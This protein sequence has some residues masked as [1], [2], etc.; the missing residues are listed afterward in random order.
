[1]ADQVPTRDSRPANEERK[2]P[3]P[4]MLRPK[5]PRGGPTGQPHLSPLSWII[6]LLL[7]V[8]NLWSFFP[9]PTSEVA[10][11]YTAFVTQV[12]GGN[13]SNARIVGDAIDGKFVHP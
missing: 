3:P 6:F 13:V 4:R 1:M 12:G 7:M 2:P 11:P 9:K 8:W 10:L 5:A